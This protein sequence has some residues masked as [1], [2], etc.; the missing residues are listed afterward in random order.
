MKMVN[1]DSLQ[2]LYNTLYNQSENNVTT[3]NKINK[4]KLFG[5][6]FQIHDISA[7]L[8]CLFTECT[9]PFINSFGIIRISKIVIC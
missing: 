9:K 6:F 7:V 2:N 5:K 4:L 1:D 3:F 8:L